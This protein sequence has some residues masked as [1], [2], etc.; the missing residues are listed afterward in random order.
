MSLLVAW[1]HE[2]FPLSSVVRFHFGTAER[3]NICS[4]VDV[5]RVPLVKD[6]VFISLRV[7]HRRTRVVEPA[8]WGVDVAVWPPTSEERAVA[9]G[10]DLVGI[11]G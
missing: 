1:P 2:M 11:D 3:C 9:H 10:S 5:V 6:V 7:V 8:S 4:P